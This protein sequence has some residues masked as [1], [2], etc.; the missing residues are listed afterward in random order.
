MRFREAVDEFARRR[1]LGHADRALIGSL[2]GLVR[3]YVEPGPRNLWR[4]AHRVTAPTLLVSG[5]HDEATP[6]IV[7]QIHMRIAGSRWELF[8]DSAHVPHLEEP[9]RFLEVVDEFLATTV[10]QPVGVT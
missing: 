10:D 8:E 5:G 9:E 2:R 3:S 1:T 7:E 4:Q 6:H